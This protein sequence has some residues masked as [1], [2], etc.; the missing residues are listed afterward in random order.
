VPTSDPQSIHLPKPP[1][2]NQ[3]PFNQ[4]SA[5]IC[6]ISLYPGTKTNRSVGGPSHEKPSPT[7]STNLPLSLRHRSVEIHPNLDEIQQDLHRCCRDSTKSS[8]TF[9]GCYSPSISIKTD[10]CP[11]ELKPTQ[12]LVFDSRQQVNCSATRSC[13]V[14][15]E[16]GTNSTQANSWTTL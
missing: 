12:P 8:L 6:S 11:L 5:T 16:L 4:K 9:K 1:S 10:R 13:R 14:S 7:N 3:K 15:S 2:S